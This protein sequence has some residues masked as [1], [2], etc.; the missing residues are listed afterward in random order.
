MS[1]LQVTQLT[2]AYPGGEPVLRGVDVEVPEGSVYCLLGANGSGKSTLLACILGFVT[3][4]A[5]RILVDGVDVVQQPQSARRLLAYVPESVSLW[6]FLTGVEHVGFFAQMLGM[7]ASPEE[8]L[9]RV[10]LPSE[11]WRRRVAGYSKGMRQKLA[12]ALATM[13]K[14]K[15]ALLDEPTSGLDPESAGAM[16]GLLRSLSAS[17]VAV[18]VVTHDVWL[19]EKA[20]DAYGILR[21]GRILQQEEAKEEGL[22]LL[23]RREPRQG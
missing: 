17:G 3:P 10:G 22:L 21:G 4:Q 1:A 6:G 9:G 23:G 19:V 5:G 14:A 16:V 8:V 11:S 18:L 7:P 2:F 12:L 13:G 20:A 15:V